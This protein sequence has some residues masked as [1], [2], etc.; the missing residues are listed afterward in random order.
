M[1]GLRKSINDMYG[2]ALMVDIERFKE[3]IKNEKRSK[4]TKEIEPIR[5]FLP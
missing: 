5:H 4:I 3:M 2:C 1:V